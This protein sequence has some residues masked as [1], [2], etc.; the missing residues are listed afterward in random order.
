M[1]DQSISVVIPFYNARE[2]IAQAVQSAL[3]Q[4]ETG[5]VIIVE[6]GSPDDGLHICEQLADTHEKVRLL[7]HPGGENRGAAASRNLGITHAVYPYVAF[8]DAD[9]F[10]LPNRFFQTR[11]VFQEHR[12]ADGVY[13][14]VGA[15]FHDPETRKIYLDCGLPLL[16]TVRQKDIPPDR[17]FVEFMK[18]G[19]GHFHFNALTVK[20]SFIHSTGCFDERLTS[21]FEDTDLMYKLSAL[22][23]LYP[24]NTTDPVAMRRVHGNNRVT[25]YLSDKKQTYYSLDK[26]WQLL[27]DWGTKELAGDKRKWLL[28]RRF[29]QLRQIDYTAPCTLAEFSTARLKMV[30]LVS[31]NPWMLFDF[32]CWRRFIPAR[33]LVKAWV[34]LTNRDLQR[35]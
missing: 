10:Y 17:L 23:R 16:T 8:L 13:E 6:D 14:A 35:D 27:L 22:G 32:F 20:T 31:K 7:R 25:Q 9:D 18:S 28:R 19:I 11:R 33:P 5:E 26:L 21:V 2:F 15:H 12:D 30:K 1:D 34:N 4:D 29:S 24:G 3:A